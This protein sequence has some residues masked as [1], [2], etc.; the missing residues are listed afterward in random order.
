MPTSRSIECYI[1]TSTGRLTEF[2]NPEDAEIILPK[3]HTSEICYIL[4]STGEQFSITVNLL[5]GADQELSK[6]ATPNHLAVM[7]IVGGLTLPSELI[8]IPSHTGGYPSGRTI[9]HV[10]YLNTTT[11]QVAA[12]KRL[13][14]FADMEV[15]EDDVAGK[16]NLEKAK[17]LGEITI[18]VKRYMKTGD[19]LQR[20]ANTVLDKGNTAHEKELKGRDI[21][22][23]VR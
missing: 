15:T 22:H 20:A 7:P 3:G 5:P 18:K 1:S 2:P 12:E 11:T 17:L 4:A 10:R 8:L 23:S 6:G 13:M 21:S 9:E 16:I 19:L 14:L